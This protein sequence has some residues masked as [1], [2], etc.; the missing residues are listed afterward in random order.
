MS[1]IAN[2]LFLRQAELIVGTKS[3]G[4]RANVVPADAR[5]LKD[6]RIKFTVDKTSEFNANK[7]TITVFNISQETRNF[8]EKKDNIVI[9]RAGYKDSISTIFSGDVLKGKNDRKG[10]DITT[11]LE[12]GDGE[13]ALRDAIVN[14]GLGP[15]ATNTQIINAAIEAITSLS[16]ARGFV[17]SIPTVTFN[18]GFTYS[19]LAK[20]LLKDQL[21]QV[22]LEYSIQDGELCVFTHNKTDQQIAVEVTPETGLVGFPT[23]SA[24]GVDFTSLL[25][26]YIRPGR[27]VKIESK[28]FQGA[29]GSQAAVASNSLVHS[30]AVVRTRRVVHDGDTHEGTW[31]SKVE[32]T[33]IGG[34]S[35]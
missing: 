5:V 7:A 25:N 28:Q 4:S 32:C 33:A 23:K 35:G 10:P 15:G 24:E 17:E 30:G 6:I 31:L 8:L 19:G 20:S 13:I 26:P 9:L 11:D 22:G 14:I 2:R 16:V 12:C 21:K 34:A 1:L 3:S 29:F 27:A 18:Q